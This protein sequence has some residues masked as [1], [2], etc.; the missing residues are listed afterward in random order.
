MRVTLCDKCKKTI[1]G[2][3]IYT[4]QIRQLAGETV[5]LRTILDADRTHFCSLSCLAAHITNIETERRRAEASENRVPPVG[6]KAQV[7]VI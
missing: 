3:V 1:D 7:Q 5:A 4:A 6:D 2:C